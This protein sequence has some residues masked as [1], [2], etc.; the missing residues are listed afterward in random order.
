MKKYILTVIAAI[1][2]LSITLCGVV[3]NSDVYDSLNK[4]LPAND[5]S[6]EL[7]LCSLTDISNL[8]TSDE[9]NNS[10]YE[11]SPYYE[12]K[13]DCFVHLPDYHSSS[14]N[15]ANYVGADKFDEWLDETG[16]ENYSKT[17]QVILYDGCP[18]TK[19]NIYEFIKHFNLSKEEF[20]DLWYYSSDY[21]I[22]DHNPDILFSG[23]IE[24]IEEYY[25]QD[26]NEHEQMMYIRQSERSFLW[27]LR[28]LYYDDPVHS[29]AFREVYDLGY[30]RFTIPDLIY[31]ADLPRDEVEEVYEIRHKNSPYGCYDYDFEMIYEQK[32]VLQAAMR[33]KTP[34]EINEMVR[35]ESRIDTR[36]ADDGADKRGK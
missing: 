35:S 28:T 6:D 23:D 11:D 22:R 31:S 25:R 2:L 19:C 17:G 4:D 29:E 20:H 9:I 16:K 33:T 8:D 12:Y 24:L 1:L 3:K 18:Y 13:P 30:N 36:T 32:E 10:N 26:R 21:Y 15:Y 5:R 14:Y 7:I 34:E 27:D